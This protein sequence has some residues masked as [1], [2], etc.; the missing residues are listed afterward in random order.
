MKQ[1]HDSVYQQQHNCLYSST[2]VWEAKLEVRGEDACWWGINKVAEVGVETQRPHQMEMIAIETY[3]WEVIWA[4]QQ[5]NYPTSH[6]VHNIARWC[7]PS[8]YNSGMLRA[9]FESKSLYANLRASHCYILRVHKASIECWVTLY[10]RIFSC[11]SWIC[12]KHYMKWEVFIIPIPFPRD[13]ER[14]L[15]LTQFQGKIKV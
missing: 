7:G 6:D 12:T 9:Q 5:L 13:E 15:V 1:H 3:N 2:I 14:E 10:G 8:R 11:V 4:I